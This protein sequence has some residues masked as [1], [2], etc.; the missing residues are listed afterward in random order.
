V[1]QCKLC[2]VVYEDLTYFY[3]HSSGY[4]WTCKECQ[5]KRAAMWAKSNKERRLEIV[6]KSR[7]GSDV[8]KK[9]SNKWKSVNGETAKARASRLNRTPEWLTEADWIAIKGVYAMRE[10]VEKCLGIK[11]HVDHIIPLR[12]EN[13]SGLHV[14]WNLSVITAASNLRKNNKMHFQL[15]KI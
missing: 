8:W 3:R 9:Y 5:K 10:R 2:D 12:G 6:K 4:C 11:H 13:V 15:S 1:R 14:P 7:A